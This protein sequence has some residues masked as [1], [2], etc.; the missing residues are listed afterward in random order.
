MIRRPPRS[1]LFPYT[2][3][4]RS[5][6]QCLARV[7]TGSLQISRQRWPMQKRQF[8]CNEDLSRGRRGYHA[9]LHLQPVFL[10][11]LP[12]PSSSASAS[13]RQLRENALSHCRDPL[14]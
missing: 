10:I 4:F 6:K 7:T 9:R 12:P 2:T 5:N 11:D 1:T 8:V 13:R 3:L 14:L